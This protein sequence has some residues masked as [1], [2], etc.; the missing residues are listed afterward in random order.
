MKS[1]TRHIAIAIAISFLLPVVGVLAQSSTTRVYGTIKDAAGAVVAG[2]KIT[3]IENASGQVLKTTTTTDEGTFVFPDIASGVYTVIAEQTGFKRAEVKD[4]K[5]DVGIPTTVNL[6]LEQG[7]IGETVTVTAADSQSVIHS[8]NAEL[9]NVVNQRQIV[10]LPLNGRNPLQ[11]AGLQAGVSGNGSTRTAAINGLRGTF[12]NL[13]WDGI[14]INDN[15]VRTDG[16]F[17]VAAPSVEGVSEFSLTTQNSGPD[18]GTGVAQVRL[19]TPRGTQ[20][21]HGSAFEFH[22]NNV[23]DSNTFFNN[24][25]GRFTAADPQVLAGLRNVGEQRLPRPKLIRNQFGFNLGGPVPFVLKDKLFFYGWYEGTRERA[26]LSQLRT[27]L[28]DTAR[29]GLFTYRRTDN[30]AL[31]TVNLLSLGGRSLDSKISSLLALTPSPND[32]TTG[33]VFNTAGFR[34]NNPNPTNSDIWGFRI[35]YDMSERHRFEAIFDR[36]TFSFPNDTFNDIGSVFPGLIGGG[37]SSQRPRG[38]FAWT[39]TPSASLTNELRGGFA[40]SNPFFF[41]NETFADGYKLTFPISTNP[42]QTFSPQGRIANNYD[43]LDNASWVKGNHLVRFGGSYRIIHTDNFNDAGIVPTY[44]LGFNTGGNVNPLNRTNQFP[45]IS[46]NDFTTATN[47]LALISGAVSSATQTFNV[48]DTTTGFVKDATR[49]REI[50]Y[51]NLSLYTGDAWRWKPNLTVNAGV[52]WEFNSVPTEKNSLALL[53]VDNTIQG[54]LNP[55]AE[56]SFAGNSSSRAFFDNDFNNFAPSLSFAWDPFKDGKTSIRGG[57]AISYVIDNNITTVQNAFLGNAGLSSGLQLTNLGG[58]VST[59]GIVPITTPAFKVPRT[60]AD[61]IAL[62][63]QT[64]LF[65]IQQDLATPYVQQ[66]NISFEREIFKDTAIEVRYVGNR[67]TKLT[68]GIDLNQVEVLDNGFVD[69][70]IRAQQNLAAARARAATV[71]S[72]PISGAFNSNVPGSQPLTIFPRFGGN[73][74]LNGGSLNNA[75][76]IGLLDTNQVGELV[77]TYLANRATFFGTGSQVTPG[78]FVLNPNAFAVDVIGNSSY[79]TY[80]G[81]QMELRK[82]LRN[83]LYFQTNY[84]FSKALTDFEGSQSNFSGLLNNDS[85]FTLEKKRANFDVTH[86]FK[87][88]WIYELPIGKGKSFLGG[89]DGILDGFIGGWQLGGILQAR[90]GRPISITSGSRGTLNRAARSAN[91]TVNTTLSIAELQR[92]VGSFL[93][94]Q[95]RPTIINPGLIGTDGRANPIAFQNP[96]PGRVG[97]LGLTPVN[98]PGFFN[99]DVNL[100]KNFRITERVGLM[101]RA[102]AFNVFNTVNYSVVEAQNINS[103]TFGRVTST[104]DP[105]ILQLSMKLS[106]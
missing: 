11:L 91:N 48:N 55:Q 36:F 27:V 3:L 76:V 90:S 35:D 87:A 98:G 46:A 14:N 32:P 51:Y 75:T 21:Y 53:P 69:D 82:R 43:F 42:V 93:D 79:S 99:L 56:L 41:N 38:S 105:R 84:T 29:N 33:D 62:D 15:F 59:N 72:T 44:T 77:A 66:W 18:A 65:T 92:S 20:S 12:S 58:T 49:F 96:A 16:L 106:F 10:D 78:F 8:E 95:G 6:D 19:V 89:I 57:Y 39:W 102:E 22:R 2:A 52:R 81:L 54:L 61:N 37:Q 17:G 24:A 94:A 7:A 26:D 28:T 68:R 70:F 50:D 13:T 100:L 47:I 31:M 71:P 45:G 101:F 34:F 80:H 23:F 25:A 1:L 83:G 97:T 63:S 103:T 4:I 40:G 60:L 9:S 73:G 86:V 74:S 64:A 30:N 67:G 5:V 88:N 85:G 104:F